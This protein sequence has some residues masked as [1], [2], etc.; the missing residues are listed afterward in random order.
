MSSTLVTKEDAG[1]GRRKGGK[2]KKERQKGMKERAREKKGRKETRKEGG[3]EEERE[4]PVF[5]ITLIC[6]RENFNMCIMSAKH[7][8]SYES[9]V[10]HNWNKPK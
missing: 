3:R 6:P 10:F 2:E 1:L 7:S 4:T 9:R 8:S 5:E